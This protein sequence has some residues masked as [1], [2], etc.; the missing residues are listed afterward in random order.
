MKGNLSTQLLVFVYGKLPTL[1]HV[2]V[3]C[4]KVKHWSLVGRSVTVIACPKI[5]CS[6][7]VVGTHLST[8]GQF[9][10]CVSGSVASQP[11]FH[12]IHRERSPPVHLWH[13]ISV[14]F[15]SIVRRRRRTQ[16]ADNC[17]G[18]VFW[19]LVPSRS[20]Y[21]RLTLGVSVCLPPLESRQDSRDQKSRVHYGNEF[22]IINFHLFISLAL[23]LQRKVKDRNGIS[24]T[25]SLR[26]DA[27]SVNGI[28]LAV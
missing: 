2:V 16:A 4:P 14:M 8:S 20:L 22:K 21:T 6:E 9:K 17:H 5:A 23:P 18:W 28:W 15:L 13:P 1:E 26:T 7:A 24:I 3:V 19:K 10:W 12:L 27:L 25:H 11:T